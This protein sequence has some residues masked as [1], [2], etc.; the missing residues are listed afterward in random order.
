MRNADMMN[1]NR[2]GYNAYF[3]DSNVSAL[4]KARMPFYTRDQA[5]GVDSQNCS[6]KR[7][8]LVASYEQKP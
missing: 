4:Q 6:S 7:V 1:E 5:A 3:H 2:A 8:E